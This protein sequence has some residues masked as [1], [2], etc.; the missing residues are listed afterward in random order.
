MSRSCQSGI[1]SVTGVTYPRTIRAKPAIR[2]DR[3]GFFL[4]GIALEPFCPARNASDSSRTSVRCPCRTSSATASHTVTR[5][6]SAETHSAIPSRSTTWVATSAGARPSAT[7]AVSSTDGSSEEYVPTAPETLATATADRARRSRSRDRAAPKARSASRWPKTSGSACTPWVRPT[8]SVSRCSSALSRRVATSASALA[9]SRSVASTSC[10]ASAVSSRSEEVRPKW[11]YAAA[12]RGLVLSAQADRK[13]MTSC[14]VTSSM[15]ATAAGVGGRAARTGSTA[16]S[17]TVPA[18]ACASSTSL[19][20]RHHSSYLCASLQTAPISG[21]VYRSITPAILAGRIGYGSGAAGRSPRSAGRRPARVGDP[22]RTVVSRLSRPSGTDRSDLEPVAA[23]PRGAPAG[24]AG[25]D[26]V[27]HPEEDRTGLTGA[28]DPQVDHENQAAA[29][30]RAVH[31]TLVADR[32]RDPM[33]NNAVPR[34]MQIAAAWAWRVVALAAAGWV[35]LQVI[36]RTQLVLVPV[37]VALLLSALLQPIAAALVKRR[38]PRALATALVLLGGIAG[39]GLLVW[40]VVDQFRNG[41]GDLTS[42]VEGG[43][44]AIRD[45]LVTGPLG[46][47]QTQ[48]DNAIASAENSLRENRSPLTS[49]AVG[50]ATTAGH[51]LTGLLIALFCTFFLVKDGS[52]IWAWVVRLFPRDIRAR[53]DGAGQRA[54]HTLISYVRATLAVVFLGS[55]VPIIGATLSGLVAVLVALVAKGPFTALLLLGVV[56]LVQQLEGHVLQ[57]LLLGRAV[58]VQ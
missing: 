46:L 12:S 17:G 38:V 56:L 16:E 39:I 21:S 45:W 49:G 55:F 29:Q 8:R 53:A 28:P 3:I 2:S 14:W 40:L 24:G 32:R 51:V 33:G 5:I 36:A 58:S 11:T 19:S 35:L 34:G 13:A 37:L 15:A 22:R 26:P 20:T 50:A 48:I 10:T 23:E 4:C 42:Q 30:D 27:E 6:A 43:I 41:L 31:R 7:A 54:W 52:Q 1:P 9:S 47:S 18:A 25:P 44:E 57:P